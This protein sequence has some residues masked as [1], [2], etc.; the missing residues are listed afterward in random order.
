MLAKQL[1]LTTI[2]YKD[3][4]NFC[5]NSKA[6]VIEW[7]DPLKSGGSA[8]I[9]KP[10]ILNPEVETGFEIARINM[11]SL[12]SENGHKFV[13]DEEEQCQRILFGWVEKRKA[14]LLIR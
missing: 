4:S 11:C 9:L 1:L 7:P 3:I 2:V 5:Q 14:F 8:A 12:A 13:S 6:G 10:R